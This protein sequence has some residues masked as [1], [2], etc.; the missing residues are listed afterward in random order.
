MQKYHMAPNDSTMKNINEEEFE[1]LRKEAKKK[2]KLAIGAAQ[3]SGGTIPA[4]GIRTL[5]NFNSSVIRS[6]P[7][8]L[9]RPSLTH[10]TVSSIFNNLIVAQSF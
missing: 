5:E 1:I 8:C 10:Q 3:V 7:N 4:L 2:E 9:S 6:L